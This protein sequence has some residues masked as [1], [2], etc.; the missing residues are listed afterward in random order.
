VKVQGKKISLERPPPVK[1]LW[2]LPDISEFATLMQFPV[3]EEQAFKAINR[4]F[5]SLS[6]SSVRNML[7]PKGIKKTDFKKKF[8]KPVFENVGKE[9][10]K[11]F[12]RLSKSVFSDHKVQIR[13]TAE[14]LSAVDHLPRESR[15]KSFITQRAEAVLQARE[16]SRIENN[17]PAGVANRS[18]AIYKELSNIPPDLVDKVF[19]KIIFPIHP[20]AVTQNILEP[21]D[22]VDLVKFVTAMRQDFYLGMFATQ[23]SASLFLSNIFPQY[24]ND[25]HNEKIN[26]SMVRSVLQWLMRE[27]RFNSWDSFEAFVAAPPPDLSEPADSEEYAK[28]KMKGWR[29][30]SCNCRCENLSVCKH[31]GMSLESMLLVSERVR[32]HANWGL[33]EDLVDVLDMFHWAKLFDNLQSELV[34]A[35]LADDTPDNRYY[36]IAR[37]EFAHQTTRFSSYIERFC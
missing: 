10:R 27:L 14:W 2:V 19:N 21:E 3:S 33:R 18:R 5:G 15:L 7:K 22:K 12:R 9:F 23:P 20:K 8:L 26:A 34:R 25:F 37:Q 29:K 30:S 6:D 4:E 1:D 32:S 28:Y 24:V 13:N 11:N 36:V 16:T 35:V 31:R 17:D